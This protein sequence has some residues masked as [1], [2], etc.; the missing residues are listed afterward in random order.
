MVRADVAYSAVPVPAGTSRV[1]LDYR[2]VKLRVG[3]VASVLA[4]AGLV[5]LAASGAGRRDANEPAP[6][7]GR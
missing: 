3:E 6:A 4:I 5:V 7:G 1:V 2:P